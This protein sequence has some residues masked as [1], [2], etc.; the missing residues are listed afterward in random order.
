[1]DTTTG[2]ALW[3]TPFKTGANRNVL[4]PILDGNS[5]L[6]ASYT[7]GLRRVTL[8][9]DGSHVRATQAW[10]NPALKINLSTPVLVGRHLYGHGPDKDFVCVDASTGTIQWRQPGFNQ[11]AST[12]ASGSRLLVLNDTGEV[13][14]LEASPARYTELGRFQ[15]CGKTFSHPA[16]AHGVLYTR[17]SREL[18]AWPLQT[19]A[20]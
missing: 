18:A 17:D 19:S 4:T 1:L 20:R 16:Y 8:E 3:R 10:L 6:F 14:L 7:T 12:V 2:E 9:A 5:V 11:Y 13:I 15:A